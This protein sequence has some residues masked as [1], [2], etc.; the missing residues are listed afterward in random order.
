MTS[1]YPFLEEDTRGAGFMSPFSI[2][3]LSHNIPF[4]TDI[5][6]YQTGMNPVLKRNF[7]RLRGTTEPTPTPKLF[8]FCVLL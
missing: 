2:P 1:A 6:F 5:P 4:A 7:E 3:Y 8:S